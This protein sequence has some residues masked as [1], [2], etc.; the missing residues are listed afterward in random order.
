MK[1]LTD[2]EK[3]AIE[4]G[5]REPDIVNEWRTC[6]FALFCAVCAILVCGVVCGLCFLVEYLIRTL[7]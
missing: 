1:K 4:D 7:C 5:V 3:K 6:L 2:E